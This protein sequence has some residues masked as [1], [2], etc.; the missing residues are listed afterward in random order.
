[1]IYKIMS[2]FIVILAI[3]STSIPQQTHAQIHAQIGD[4][5]YLISNICLDPC[6]CP[7]PGPLCPWIAQ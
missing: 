4:I 6:S 3:T 5:G 2:I 1:M 7:C